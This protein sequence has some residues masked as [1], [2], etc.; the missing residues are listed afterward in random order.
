[1]K[2]DGEKREYASLIF[3]EGNLLGSRGMD[4]ASGGM[5]RLF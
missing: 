5:E 3:L 1:M 2:N 4:V